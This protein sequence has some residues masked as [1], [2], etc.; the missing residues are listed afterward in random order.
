MRI[1]DLKVHRPRFAAT[2]PAAAPAV[3][4]SP[5]PAPA[6]GRLKCS[7]CGGFNADDART[8]QACDE[9]L[10]VT[11]A[12]CSLVNLRSRAVCRVC[13][14]HLRNTL[15]RKLKHWFVDRH[16]GLV[17]KVVLV[18]VVSYISSKVIFRLAQM[19]GGERDEG[20][21]IDQLPTEPGMTTPTAPPEHEPL[22]VLPP[23]GKKK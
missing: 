14:H 11:C 5:A 9:A 19:G 20:P 22:I 21:P 18:L 3:A 23:A 13:G 2:A 12:E 15:F 7:K 4:R 8:C 17:R 10:Y 16:G 6:P 1:E